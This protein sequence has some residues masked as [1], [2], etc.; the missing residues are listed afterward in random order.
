MRRALRELANRDS[1]ST[2]AV[3]AAE[4]RVYSPIGRARI[5]DDV[6]A[7]VQVG[8]RSAARLVGPPA[9]PILP[10]PVIVNSRGHHQGNF[11]ATVATPAPIIAVGGYQ[12][13]RHGTIPYLATVE[14]TVHVTA[15]P[16]GLSKGI[17]PEVGG[18]IVAVVAILNPVGI[19][20]EVRL[21]P[22]YAAPYPGGDR[23]QYD[24]K[25]SS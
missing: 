3:A 22:G 10:I 7:I 5:S 21:V 24:I 18:V 14:A 4:H 17:R 23:Y 13:V 9:I 12:A 8:C 16:T 2:D 19:V 25:E 6:A 11:V 15:G 20:P 1:T